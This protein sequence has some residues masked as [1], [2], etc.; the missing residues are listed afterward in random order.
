MASLIAA[1]N[2][3]ESLVVRRNGIR[4]SK[5]AMSCSDEMGGRAANR[6]CPLAID[7]SLANRRAVDEAGIAG[8]P[9][10]VLR[11]QDIVVELIQVGVL[12]VE[13]ADR[14]RAEWAAKH[15]FRLK[16][17]SFRDLL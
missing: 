16:I 2:A 4:P 8:N 3:S 7:D 1:M 11:T 10:T 6:K 5:M 9:L 13:A 15:R 17:S 12:S 14:I